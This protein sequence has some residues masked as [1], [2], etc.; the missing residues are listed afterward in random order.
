MWLSGQLL[1]KNKQFLLFFNFVLQINRAIQVKSNI[2]FE[3][4][5]LIN[6]CLTQSLWWTKHFVVQSVLTWP[7]NMITIVIENAH[8]VMKSRQ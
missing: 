8:H 3:L 6:K 2:F 1:I 5:L 4:E 7:Y